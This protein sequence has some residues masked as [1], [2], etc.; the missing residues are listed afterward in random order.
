MVFPEQNHVR[1]WNVVAPR[2]G[3]SYN[4]SGDGR[5]VIKA[6]G[7]WYWNNPGTASSNPNPESWFKRHAWTDTNGNG[8]WNAGEEG[9]LIASQ[10]GVATTSLDL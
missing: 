5:T 3:A 9:R 7:G 4:L 2:L 1:V 6:N 8:F 10:G